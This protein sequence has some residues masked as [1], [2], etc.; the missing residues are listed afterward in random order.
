[1]P[2]NQPFE[3]LQVFCGESNQ[4]VTRVYCAL[5]DPIPDNGVLRGTIRGPVSA[6]THTLPATV[7]LEYLGAK[8]RPLVQAHVVDPCFWGPGQPYLYDVELE[9]VVGGRAIDRMRRTIG[10]RPVGVIGR[11]LRLSL[12][13]WFLRGVRVWADVT[14]ELADWRDRQLTPCSSEAGG[15][16]LHLASQEGVPAVLQLAGD[17]AAIRA[18]LREISRWPCCVMALIECSEMLDRSI[19]DLSPNL[20]LA[21]P[22]SPGATAIDSWADVGIAQAFDD[23]LRDARHAAG[24]PIVLTVCSERYH[25]LAEAAAAIDHWRQDLGEQPEIAG[26]IV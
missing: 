20:L 5:S 12:K 13:P 26:I 19:R 9:L 17:Q 10:L 11:Q 4:N 6:L 23:D 2:A 22:F 1:V 18:G 7:D 25:D 15:L 3:S 24:L 14:R 16:D 21:Q 8:P